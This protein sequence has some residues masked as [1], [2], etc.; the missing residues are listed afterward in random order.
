MRISLSKRGKFSLVL[1]AGILAT[2]VACGCPTCT[3]AQ[4]AAD[5]ACKA[6]HGVDSHAEGVQCTMVIGLF[7]TCG[8]TSDWGFCTDGGDGDGRTFPTPGEIISL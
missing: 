4:K 3:D 5:N 8:V 6:E 2:F 1:L 7:E